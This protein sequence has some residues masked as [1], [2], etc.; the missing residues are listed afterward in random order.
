MKRFVR[1]TPERYSANTPLSS[2]NSSCGRSLRHSAGPSCSKP[3]PVVMALNRATNG[4]DRQPLRNNYMKAPKSRPL[5]VGA[6]VM[7]RHPWNRFGPA[8]LCCYFSPPGR[9]VLE[10][11][12]RIGRWT[13]YTPGLMLNCTYTKA[14]LALCL[15]PGGCI[16]ITVVTGCPPSEWLTGITSIIK[17]GLSSTPARAHQCL[18][19]P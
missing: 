16:G 14:V 12:E 8:L 17:L 6:P 10:E 4:D 5:A 9:A 15:G 2:R 1:W 7:A 11:R 18:R 19:S 3:A 13:F